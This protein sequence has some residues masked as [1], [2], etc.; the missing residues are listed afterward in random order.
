MQETV[1]FASIMLAIGF[2]LIIKGGDIFVDA[3]IYFAEVTRIPKL[4]IGATV[5][6]LCTTLPE[7]M[8]STIAVTS[9]VPDMGI[10]NALGSIV[11]N[12]ALILGISVTVLPASIHKQTF[13]AKAAFL[14]LSIIILFI[15]MLDKNIN[16]FEGI[17]LEIGRAHV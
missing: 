2:V 14:I 13:R 3:T 17:L 9:G 12:T 10:G 5:I 8:V 15:F 11:C 1:W 4:L 16:M 6:S 7:L